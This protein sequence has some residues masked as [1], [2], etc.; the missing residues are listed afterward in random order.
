MSIRRHRLALAAVTGAGIL[1]MPGLALAEVV[2]GTGWTRPDDYSTEGWR[3]DNLLTVS[4]VLIGILFLMMVVWLVWSFV[5]HG[6]KHE[7]VYDHGTSRIW[8]V[9]KLA[10][11]GAI[12]FGVD[13]NLF[14]NSSLDMGRVY[15]NFSKVDDQPDVVRVEMNGR[16]W[17]W[18]TRLPG[19]DGTFGT[20]DDVVGLNELTVPAGRPVLF[21]IGAVDVLHCLYI[22]NLRIKQDAVPGMITRAWFEA[23]EPGE[24]EI[25]C[26]QH[27]GVNHYKMRGVLRVVPQD[28]FDRWYAEASQSAALAFDPADVDSSWGW[29]WRPI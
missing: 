23:K 9:G 4:L 28:D 11:A 20:A 15:W 26:C 25:A 7:A 12:F 18:A 19:K 16:Q 13:G 5:L 27:C 17:A 22:P 6:E 3:T 24:F 8:T 21:Q 1:F 10:L 29:P 2:K 14:V